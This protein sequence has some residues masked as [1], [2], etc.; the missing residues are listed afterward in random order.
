MQH[1]SCEKPQLICVAPHLVDAVWPHAVAL[2]DSAL[3]RSDSDLTA[4]H[5][6]AKIDAGRSYLWI[7][8]NGS[9]L[10]SG[11]TEVVR[12]E[13]GRRICVITTCA[14]RDHHIWERVLDDIERYARN[15]GCDA[16]RFHGRMGWVRRLKHRGYAQPYVIVERKL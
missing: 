4:A 10:G 6:K 12:L 5:I 2:I 13:N 14:G 1:H 11:T 7:I 3:R 15:E 16:V 9:L 8:W